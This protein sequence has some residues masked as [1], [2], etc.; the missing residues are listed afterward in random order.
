MLSGKTY[1]GRMF[2]DA[3]YE[4]DLMAAAG[5]DYHVGREA[6]S[7][8]GETWN[9][10]QVGVLHHGHHFGKV[11]DRALRR[12]RRSVERRAA[13][14]QRRSAGQLRRRRPPR[15]GVL[16]PHV[17]DRRPDNRIPFPETRRLRSEAVR[18]A[19]CASIAAGWDETFAKFDP[20]PNHKT[21]TNN[22]GP[23]STD[24]IGCNYDY[25][26]ATYERRRAIIREHETYQKGWLYFVA[27]DPRVP[28]RRADA[29]CRPT[30]CRRTSSPTT[31][32]GRT[33]STSAR[34]GG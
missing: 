1:A 26:E 11:A 30:A 17:P 22:H 3:T 27:N 7:V 32:T 29:R 4:G 24:N 31:A 19:G 13:P 8:Y 10:V 15:A 28:A 2:I 33:R 16:L 9:G 21:D 14:H 20:I 18:A 25:P 6:A 34:P 5:V 23:I 12:A